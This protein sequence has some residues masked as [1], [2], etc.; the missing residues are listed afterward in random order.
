VRYYSAERGEWEE[1]PND[2]ID[3]DATNRY[4][5][6]R[7]KAAPSAEALALDK[8]LDAAENDDIRAPK[9]AQGLRLPPTGG[10]FVVDSYKGETQLLELSQT[11]GEVNRNVKGN[12]LRAAVNPLASSKQTIELQGLHAST[13]SHVTTPVLYINI[14]GEDTQGAVGSASPQGPQKPQG[15]QQ[16]QQPVDRFRIVR[17]KAKKDTRVV[18]TLSIAVY[19]KLSQSE[20]FVQAESVTI[21]GGWTKLTPGKPLEPG[22]YAVVETLGDKEINL[23]VWDFGVNP[24]A[25]ENKSAWR[26]VG[27]ERVPAPKPP[28]K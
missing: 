19:G 17:L 26:P 10:V 27:V 16:P 18:G 21:G 22:E 28:S 5:A 12:I 24:A 6:D 14:E 3:W 1:V 20:S 4:E 25:G 8:E 9:V 15:P 13:Q 23:Y 11:G 7:L 2:L